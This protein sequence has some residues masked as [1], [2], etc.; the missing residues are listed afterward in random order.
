[1]ATLCHSILN[2][3][4]GTIMKGLCNVRALYCLY[5]LTDL[6]ILSLA[7]A[8][9][10]HC[11]RSIHHVW[12]DFFLFFGYLPMGC[13]TN[14]M[15]IVA[16]VNPQSGNFQF[17]KTLS[18]I[19]IYR[20]MKSEQ[21][22]TLWSQH[23]YGLMFMLLFLFLYACCTHNLDHAYD[24]WKRSLNNLTELSSHLNKGDN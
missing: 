17:L 15:H 10:V 3:S 13:I 16:N 23:C 14:A 12:M 18:S 11:R 5:E 1:M 21:L 19:Q 24:C 2:M 8:R 20:L 22:Y 7:G 4:I 6:D 9:P